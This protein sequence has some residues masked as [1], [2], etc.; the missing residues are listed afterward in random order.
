MRLGQQSVRV[1]KYFITSP[2]NWCLIHRYSGDLMAFFLAFQPPVCV[3]CVSNT[4]CGSLVMFIVFRFCFSDRNVFISFHWIVGAR[5]QRLCCNWFICCFFFL[6]SA[7]KICHKQNDKA[8]ISRPH[9]VTV[10]QSYNQSEAYLIASVHIRLFPF[11]EK[12]NA[13]IASVDVL[14]SLCSFLTQHW[15]WKIDCA[16]MKY[17]WSLHWKIASFSHFMYKQLWKI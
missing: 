16:T 2:V 5:C 10:C 17:E 15:I 6:R 9:F 3:M 1:N 4:S 13:K 14:Y 8:H 7:S 12:R 11:N